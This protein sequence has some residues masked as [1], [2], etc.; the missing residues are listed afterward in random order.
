MTT[1]ELLKKTKELIAI[2]SVGDDRKAC[3]D[4]LE[5][6]ADFVRQRNPKV[7]IEYF[8]SNG[9]K[10]LLAYRGKK[11]PAGFHVMLNGHVDVIP[12]KPEQYK[13]KVK[14]GK[15]YGRGVYDMKA[16]CIIMADLFCE[17]VDEVPYELGLQIVT[18]EETGG[19]DGTAYQISKGVRA[20]FAISGECGRRSDVYEIANEHKGIVFANVEFGGVSTHSAYLWRGKNA[21]V[22][23][24]HFVQAIHDAYPTPDDE[25]HDTTVAVTAVVSEMDVHNKVP[26]HALVKLDIRFVPG[27]PHFESEEAI[28]K[29]VTSF[30][31]DARLVAL[32]VYSSPMY[33]DPNGE[34]I[35]DLKRAAE[36]VEGKKFTFY[37]RHAGSDGRHFTAAGG[38]ACEF[39]IA[40]EH[41]HG[42][43][44][45]VTVQ[46]FENY[47][48]TM[49]QF[50]R[51]TKVPGQLPSEK[52]ST[53]K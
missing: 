48:R 24:A 5:Y 30:H 37:R 17:F 8:G 45:H 3:N 14:D 32:P 19:F 25:Y 2:R 6:V 22:K 40:G 20:D 21:A 12:A 33:S 9:I 34:F 46:A 35:Q 47:Y 53:E 41:Q 43:D 29:F 42:D 36:V 44:E 10:S 15:L 27:D 1:D 52:K 50:L 26:D 38:Q 18:D 31:P 39:G 51:N 11:R 13:L 28:A 23:A 49:H 7:T 16:A 4:A